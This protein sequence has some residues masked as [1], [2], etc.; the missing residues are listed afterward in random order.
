MAAAPAENGLF[1][2]T[3]VTLKDMVDVKPKNP[4]EKR[5]GSAKADS[6]VVAY[7]LQVGE[8]DRELVLKNA[9]GV[10]HTWKRSPEQ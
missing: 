8:N 3:I 9:V 4:R 5:V 1:K 2:A 6:G 7:T 10:T